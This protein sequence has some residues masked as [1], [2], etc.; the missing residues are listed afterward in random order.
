MTV[1]T[2]HPIPLAATQAAW[3]E[4]EYNARAS[5]ALMRLETLERLAEGLTDADRFDAA[6]AIWDDYIDGRRAEDRTGL[7][8]T[9]ALREQAIIFA[10]IATHMSP[11][12]LFALAQAAW[13]TGTFE[14]FTRSFADGL[15]TGK[16]GWYRGDT[17][18]IRW[19]TDVPSPEFTAWMEQGRLRSDLVLR[20]TRVAL[21]PMFGRADS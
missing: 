2:I 12:E 7:P 14:V 9:D 8:A 13:G 3:F 21:H 20:G 18:V 10:R 11:K 1:R 16:V 6:Y 19:G 17:L 4:A 5:F 15:V